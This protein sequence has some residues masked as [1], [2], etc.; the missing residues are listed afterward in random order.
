MCLANG[1]VYERLPGKSQTVRDPLRLASLFSRG[2]TAR[3]EAQARADRAAFTVL[4]DWLDGAAGEFRPRWGPVAGDVGELHS[5]TD[6]S[7][8]IRFSV[9]IATTGNPP[10]ISSRLFR[11]DFAIEVWNELRDRPTQL[12]PGLAGEGPD[13]IGW[14]QDALTWRREVSLLTP[15]ITIIRAA[16][17]GSVGV[18]LKRAA[19]DVIPRYLAESGIAPEWRHAEDLAQ[20]LG[21]FG[22][23]YVTVVVVGGRFPRR[24]A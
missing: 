11:E 18:G 5:E 7:F 19:E 10:H 9:G 13:A 3:K 17:D 22:D 6:D 12:P 8:P 20:R 4:N 1:T 23:V 15:S 21:G 16:W 2:D 14:A 24:T